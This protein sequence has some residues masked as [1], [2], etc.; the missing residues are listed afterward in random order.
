[1]QCVYYNANMAAFTIVNVEK[2]TVE[3]VLIRKG[4]LTNTPWLACKQMDYV[5]INTVKYHN[6]SFDY[7]VNV[8]VP[9]V[10]MMPS[11]CMCHWIYHQ[12]SDSTL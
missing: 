2:S 8:H 5:A 1:M 12:N 11:Q 10:T 9:I 7:P 4:S 3:K 6:N